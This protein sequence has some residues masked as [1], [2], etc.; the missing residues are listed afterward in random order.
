MIK[1]RFRFNF[2]GQ[3][4][5]AFSQVIIFPLSLFSLMVFIGCM[6]GTVNSYSVVPIELPNTVFAIDSVIASIGSQS[7]NYQVI[8][9]D[10]RSS[11]SIE[12]RSSLRQ[13]ITN[14]IQTHVLISSSEFRCN[15]EF[16]RSRIARELRKIRN[17]FAQE[18]NMIGLL[19]AIPLLEEDP[20]EPF[21]SNV[22]PSAVDVGL[23]PDRR[24]TLDVY[25]FDFKSR[26]ITVELVGFRGRRNVTRALGILSEFHMVLDL[27]GNGAALDDSF[28]QIVFSWDHEPQCVVPVLNSA[29]CYLCSTYT[30]T[31]ESDTLLIKP[32]LIRGDQD[33][34]GHGPLIEFSFRL[35][36]DAIGMSL[37]A[38]YSFEGYESRNENFLIPI[39]DFTS[40]SEHSTIILYEVTD[41]R[42]R[43][44]SFNSKDYLELRYYDSNHMDDVFTFND[45]E[46]ISKLV[47]IGDLEG[48]EAGIRSGVTAYLNEIELFIERRSYE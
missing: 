3:R 28:Q 10:L 11:L 34:H 39:G 27:S 23:A 32:G 18:I 4:V 16:I 38:D 9:E 24:L 19:P 48:D 17:D 15:I 35:Y 6:G 12:T 31:T 14:L 42:D 2:F 40:V 47:F 13:E 41:P 33:F 1:Y 8:L 30:V 45:D 5:F 44:I 43:I 25:G 22:V 20:L 37:R 21:I 46:P 7:D 29:H 36:I 26:P